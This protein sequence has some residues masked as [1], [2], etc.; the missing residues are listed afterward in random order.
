MANHSGKINVMHVIMNLELAGAQEVVRTLAEYLQEDDCMVTVCALRDGPMRAEIEKMG[1]KVEIV[2]HPRY[3]FMFSPR[4]LSEIRRFRRDL[5][6]LVERYDIDILQTHLLETFDFLIL[7]L[8]RDTHLRGIV[9]TI[10]SVDFMPTSL[11]R[12]LVRPKKFAYRLF[13]R[14]AVSSVAGFIAVSDEVREAI[15]RQVGPTQDK[16]ITIPNG[17]DVK[18]YDLAGDKAALCGQ[19]GLATN[20]KLVATVGRLTLPKG[21]RYLIDAAPSVVSVYSETHFLFIGDGELRDELERQ[22]RETGLSQNIHFLGLRDDVPDLLAAVDLF[23]LP[24]L[25]E[26][27]SIALLEAMA[28][29]KPVV[30]T[31]VSGTTQV[32][33]PEKTG[34]IVP[35]G[36]SQALADAV[37][38]LLSNPA[39]ALRMGEAAKQHIVTNFSAQKQ[40]DEHVALYRR[41]LAQPA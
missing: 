13:Y 28:A 26:G 35:P 12:W 41:L 10:H 21:H 40:A 15:L 29:G 23:V 19:L 37:V 18:R 27:L 22:T 39:Q 11:R 3:D 2:R 16:V 7:T 5:A 6:R 24:S 20:A 25:W 38:W 8:Q 31:A 36:E 33:I 30:A 34:L 14:L 32:M 9:W 1:V 17:V 4:F